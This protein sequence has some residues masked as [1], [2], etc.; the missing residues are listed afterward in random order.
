MAGRHSSSRRSRQSSLDVRAEDRW[1][2]LFCA[3]ALDSIAELRVISHGGSWVQSGFLQ[4]SNW[5]FQF[6]DDYRDRTTSFLLQPVNA[7]ADLNRLSGQLRSLGA[8]VTQTGDRLRGVFEGTGLRD[9]DRVDHPIVEMFR[10]VGGSPTRALSDGRRANLSIS[11]EELYGLL[12]NSRATTEGASIRWSDCGLEWALFAEL[13]PWLPWAVT[14]KSE[15]PGAW[16]PS[17]EPWVPDSLES[18]TKLVSA[19]WRVP[20]LA[21]HGGALPSLPQLVDGVR[22]IGGR[23]RGGDSVGP[24]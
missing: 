22:G 6:F 11:Q 13:R 9:I 2:A 14:V 10:L 5:S 23:G 15:P 24:A 21:A 12:G 7:T 1:Y 20:I 4:S 17:V 3:V 18:P 8:R 16:I 19:C